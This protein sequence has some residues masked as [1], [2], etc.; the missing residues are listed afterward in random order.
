[1]ASYIWLD[2]VW[3]I[4]KIL[5]LIDIKRKRK[6]GSVGHHGRFKIYADPTKDVRRPWH[7]SPFL[8]NDL[9]YLAEILVWSIRRTLVL[10]DIK[11]KKKS[12]LGNSD[13][14]KFT[15]TLAKFT[16]TLAL[17]LFK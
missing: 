13:C 2:F 12:E 9:V 1:M 14:G 17:S 7:L 4:S 16:S 3:S 15:S 6:I 10:I 11:I 8:K 5:T